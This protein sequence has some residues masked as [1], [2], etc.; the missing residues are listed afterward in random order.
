MGIPLKT[1]YFTRRFELA[2]P[3]AVPTYTD[4]VKVCYEVCVVCGKTQD[5]K[6]TQT[7]FLYILEQVTHRLNLNHVATTEL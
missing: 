1:E 5:W 3:Q 6:L 2:P 4:E 7:P